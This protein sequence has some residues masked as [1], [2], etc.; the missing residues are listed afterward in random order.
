MHIIKYIAPAL[1]LSCL[2]F[3]PASAAPVTAPLNLDQAT[4][5]SVIQVQD[6]R[7]RHRARRAVTPRYHAGRRYS[8]APHGWHRYDRR[9][10]NWRSRNCVLVGPVWFCP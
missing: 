1:F 4:Q 7:R 3:A 5:S 2:A 10:G 6:Y 8:R 9:P